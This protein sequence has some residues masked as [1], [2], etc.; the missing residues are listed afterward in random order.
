MGNTISLGQFRNEIG[1]LSGLH[2][3][4]D[5]AMEPLSVWM[6][7]DR[8]RVTLGASPCVSLHSGSANAVLSHII[9]IRRSAKSGRKFY[10]I[11]CGNYVSSDVPAQVQF[12]LYYA[13]SSDSCT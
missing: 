13:D 5:E 8:V 9:K 3:V 11:T 12:L 4:M 7:V 1:T 2:L 10:R 6:P